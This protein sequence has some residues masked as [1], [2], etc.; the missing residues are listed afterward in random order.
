MSA[1]GDTLGA[2]VTVFAG[3]IATIGGVVGTNHK[4]SK[5][6][7]RKLDGDPD[8]PNQE[9]VLEIAHETREHVEELDVRIQQMRRETRHEHEEVMDRLETIQGDGQNG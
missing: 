9:G 4:R 5:S 3:V 2:A 8:D 7:K 6:N 1:L